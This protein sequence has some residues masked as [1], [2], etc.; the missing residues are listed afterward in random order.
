MMIQLLADDAYFWDII[1]CDI[2]KVKITFIAKRSTGV[3]GKTNDFQGS[4]TKGKW[5]K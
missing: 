3:P 4:E 5:K 2:E 1:K